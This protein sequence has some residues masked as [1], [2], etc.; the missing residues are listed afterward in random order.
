MN[1]N[2]I[3]ELGQATL[4]GSLPFPE[5]VGKLIAEG[6]EYYHVDYVIRQMSFYSDQGAVVI[7]PLSMD[8]L[9]AISADFDAPA[10]KATIHDSQVNGQ[11]FK[12]FSRRA[13][14][15]GVAGYFAFLRGK[16]VLYLGRQ[17]AQHVEW[18]PGANPA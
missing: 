13:V 9:P 5:I 17:G 4:A 16:R 8:A 2:L 1:A 11:E 14:E 6:V 3:R 18:F 15:A 12:A 10:L 7:V